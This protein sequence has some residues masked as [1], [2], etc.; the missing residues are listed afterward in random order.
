MTWFP[1]IVFVASALAVATP[2]LA[3]HRQTDAVVPLTTSGDTPL[4]RQPTPGTKT[5]V[6]S[7]EWGTGHR[8]VSISPWRDRRNPTAQTLVAD[9]GANANPVVSANGRAFAFDSASDPLGLGLPGRQVIGTLRRDQFPVSEDPTGTAVNPAI[10]G[11]GRRVAFESTADLTGTGTP[12]V[13]QVYVREGDGSVRLLSRGSGISRNPVLSPKRNLILFES[14]NDLVT[15]ADTGVT[16]I[17]VG[18]VDAGDVTPITAG[19]GPSMNPAVS[20]DGRL[21]VFE[22]TAD[23]KGTQLDTGVSQIYL[24]DTKTRTYA[25]VTDEPTGCRLPSVYKVLRGASPTYAMAYR[26]SP[27]CGRTSATS[28]PP[29]AASRSASQR[30]WASTLSWSARQGTCSREPAPRRA[31]R[32]IW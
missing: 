11:V 17:W 22:S 5:L 26:T 3:H 1:R 32:C 23:L 30:C 16:Q 21:V 15:G 2:A 12:G 19:F 4:P 9:A 13:R 24:Y 29:P 28:S 10:D 8:V 6:L 20:N 14:T 31:T 27:W 7:V 25:R 18:D